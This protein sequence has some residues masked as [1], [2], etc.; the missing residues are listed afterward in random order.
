MNINL[1]SFFG[2]EMKLVVP[3][4]ILEQDDGQRA[5]ASLVGYTQARVI[6]RQTRTPNTT[7]GGVI[8]V[9][10]SLDDSAFV[11]LCGGSAGAGDGAP[12]SSLDAAGTIVSPWCNITGTLN[13]DPVFLRWVT[14]SGSDAGGN[15][16]PRVAS[17]N[18][19]VR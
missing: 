1:N 15:D 11:F 19:Q 5:A 7:P 9:E 4:G 16:R 17:I 2:A 18:L 13:V 10:G 3:V 14:Y 12:S 6:I 8:A